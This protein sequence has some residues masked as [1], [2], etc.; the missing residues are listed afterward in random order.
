MKG[1][2]L[3]K[4]RIFLYWGREGYLIGTS[5]NLLA[6]WQC[7]FFKNREG[8]KDVIDL[9]VQRRFFKN[10]FDFMLHCHSKNNMKKILKWKSWKHYCNNSSRLIICIGNYIKNIRISTCRKGLVNSLI[11]PAHIHVYSHCQKL[12]WFVNLAIVVKILTD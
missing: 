2:G 11:I 5:R 12:A 9:Y 7:I 10:R 3:S 6:E 4:K 8:G 1:L